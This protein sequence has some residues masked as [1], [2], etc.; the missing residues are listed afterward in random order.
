MATLPIRTQIL[1]FGG[2]PATVTERFEIHPL[3][4]GVD[5]T[6]TFNY[7]TGYQ[8]GGV[9]CDGITPASTTGPGECNPTVGGGVQQGFNTDGSIQEW[10]C[11]FD[12]PTTIA[13]R[14]N[15]APVPLVGLGCGAGFRLNVYIIEYL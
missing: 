10:H 12:S 7:V 3:I 15:G 5:L 13:I 9:G 2:I 1:N 6:R 14:R 11:D 4:S 8:S